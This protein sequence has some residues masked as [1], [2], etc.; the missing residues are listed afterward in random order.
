MSS[1]MMP[2]TPTTPTI[3]LSPIVALSST[4]Q[5]IS[6]P[7]TSA[8]KPFT[9]SLDTQTISSASTILIILKSTSTSKSSSIVPTKTPIHTATTSLTLFITTSPK[10]VTLDV[11]VCKSLWNYPH[12]PDCSKY[13]TCVGIT[14]YI[15]DCP[16]PF[17]WNTRTGNCDWKKNVDCDE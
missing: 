17:W 5:S 16:P 12:L 8:S 15:R 7:L 1:S 14:Q 2:G 13:I 10:T 4:T 11:C 6:V 3:D 9:T